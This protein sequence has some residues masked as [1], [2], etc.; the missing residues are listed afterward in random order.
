MKT[1]RLRVVPGKWFIAI[2][3]SC[4][5]S[6]LLF[7][8]THAQSERGLPAEIDMYLQKL[9]PYGF[10]GAV[11][12]AQDGEIIL[13]RGYGLA[14]EKNNQPFDV[15]T[16]FGIG[17]LSKQFTASAI[18]HLEMQGR[19]KTDDPITLYLDGVPIDKEDITIHHLLT[20]TAGLRRHH[21]DNDFLSLTKAEAL[22][23]ILAE[24]L[25]YPLGKSYHYADSGY[26]ILAMIVEE[27]AGQ[28]F[29]TYLRENLFLPAGMM[30]TGF[31]GERNLENNVVAHGY[32]NRIDQGAPDTWPEPA[33][34]LLGA[35]GITSTV[36][37]L[38]RWMQAL[39]NSTILSEEIMSKLWV[40]HVSITEGFAYGY[41]W[42]I[43]ESD[44]GGRMIQHSGA[45]SSHNSDLRYFVEE[46]VLVIVGSNRIDDFLVTGR[47]HP[48]FGQ[49]D[50][51]IYGLQTSEFLGE[52][53]IKGQF[54][55][56]P[57]YTA[58]AGIYV[59]ALRLYGIIVGVV[60]SIIFAVFI[61]RRRTASASR[62]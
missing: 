2:L 44:Y 1:R 51:V 58:I 18:L 6:L 28:P 38:Y 23:I 14:N 46:D 13:Q 45:G 19:L 60:L 32:Y 43:I 27:A 17:S 7:A 49:F 59:H 36:D 4:L 47:E 42:Q 10:S 22:E 5:G 34:A 15:N 31:F 26:V 54:E 11:L 16:I 9:A 8:R 61:W 3:C 25:E 52:A 62:N 40:P 56:L 12:V 33:W 24:K 35:G 41:G 48:F 55:K 57:D 37:D 53:I 50:E 39:Q 30:R 29:Q 20:H 21:F